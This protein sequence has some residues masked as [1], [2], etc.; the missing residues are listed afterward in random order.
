MTKLRLLVNAGLLLI[1]VTFASTPGQLVAASM[2]ASV[3][4]PLLPTAFTDP[5]LYF[6]DITSGPKTGNGDTSDGRSGL[7]GAIVTVYGVN[8]GM[9][10]GAGKVYANGVEAG[11]YYA[12]GNAATP[13]DLFTFHQMQKVSFQISHLAQDGAG[14]IYVVVNGKP[15]NSLPFTVRNGIIY[16]VTTAGDDEAG[17]GSWTHPWRTLQYAAGSLN[18]GD[19]AYIRNGVN[20]SAETDYGAAV[21][22]GRSGTAGNPIALVVYPGA[23]SQVGNANIERGFWFWNGET[24]GYS[25]HW[26]IA[27]FT[28]TTGQVGIPAQTGFRIINNYITAPQ[29]DGMDGAIDV[30]GNAVRVFGNELAHVGQ[31]GCSKL[32]HAIYVKGVRLDEAPRAPTESDREIGWNYIHDNLSNR[33]INIYNEQ[34]YAAFLTQHRVHDNAIINQRGDGIMLGYYVIGENWVYNNLV[35]NA[36]LGPEWVDDPSYHTGIRINAGHEEEANTRIYVYNNTLYGNGWSGATFADESGSV[37]FHQS[38]LDRDAIIHFSN[39]I[40]YSTG[41]PY[42]AGESAALPVGAHRNCWFGDGSAPVWDTT[43]INSNPNFI[44]ATLND[45]RLKTSSPCI[46]KGKDLTAVVARDL[47]GVS[48]P[49][50]AAFDI[51]AYEFIAGTV[52]IKRT[53]YLPV[54]KTGT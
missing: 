27:G 54:I 49:Q 50:G 8:L 22:L 43:A 53:L 51:G 1:L 41:E 25:T 17:D 29:G 31:A 9:T 6:S 23:A 11:S 24:G 14:Q 47:L 3:H 4:T 16:F 39:N 33:A 19:I 38:A 45:F 34:L 28:V 21:N 44:N 32:Y 12:W 52:S 20:Q 37:L 18:P 30:A 15:S 7:D 42:L 2:P 10:R 40:I 46:N 26:V 5:V 13:A 35:V 48:R 36:G